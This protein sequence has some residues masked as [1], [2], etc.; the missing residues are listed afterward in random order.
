M[1]V[2]EEK[3]KG[4]RHFL[5]LKNPMAAIRSGG[6]VGK[7]RAFR[8]GAGVG[9]QVGGTDQWRVSILCVSCSACRCSRPLIGRRPAEGEERAVGG[10]PTCSPCRVGHREEEQL[11]P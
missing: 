2:D 1:L 6:G 9:G 10:A 11:K 5:G 4:S 7:P 8:W 3:Q